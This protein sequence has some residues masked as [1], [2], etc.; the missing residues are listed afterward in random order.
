MSEPTSAAPVL[1]FCD[2]C[3]L[4]IRDTIIIGPKGT[5]HPSCVPDDD[6]TERQMRDA[7]ALA[8]KDKEFAS[9]K[10]A[11]DTLITHLT[12]ENKAK[13][14]RIAELEAQVEAAHLTN[15]D[16]AET[17]ATVMESALRKDK[18]IA[19][20]EARDADVTMDR[21]LLWA[22]NQQ[23]AALLDRMPHHN[24]YTDGPCAPNCPACAWAKIKP[25]LQPTLDAQSPKPQTE[26][27]Q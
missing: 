25:T 17:A 18:R 22:K 7:Q 5:V 16:L 21:D 13:N 6:E 20:L 11:T 8:A 26:R 4:P 27:Q 12:E 1:G 9:L 3:K 24:Q 15:A 2:I 14:Q 19:E 10:D 23:M